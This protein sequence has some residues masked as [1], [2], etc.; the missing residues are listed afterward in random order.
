MEHLGIYWKDVHG[1]ALGSLGPLGSNMDSQIYEC[2]NALFL[3]QCQVV[4]DSG[5]GF[6]YLEAIE[7][8]SGKLTVSICAY[9]LCLQFKMD[10]YFKIGWVIKFLNILYDIWL[11][12]ILSIQII[13]EVFPFLNIYQGSTHPRCLLFIAILVSPSPVPIDDLDRLLGGSP[14]FGTG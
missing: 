5:Q 4:Y 11:Y 13:P 10:T 2:T 6:L 8:G 14:H 1:V 7:S 9:A 12:P 3:L